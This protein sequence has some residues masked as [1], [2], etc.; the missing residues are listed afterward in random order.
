MESRNAQTA[1][2]VFDCY[3]TRDY[4]GVV[5]CLATSFV[6]NDHPSMKTLLGR[7]AYIDFQK[8]WA[9]AFSDGQLSDTTYHDAGNA[10]IAECTFVGTNDGQFG[11]LP[12]TGQPVMMPLCSVW[13]FDDEGQIISQDAYYDTYGLMV[14]LGHAAA[15]AAERAAAR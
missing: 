8:G 5:G 1:R 2:R 13:K 15:P 11:P 6:M 7:D 9:T 4:A 10:V 12:A 14:Q 3:N